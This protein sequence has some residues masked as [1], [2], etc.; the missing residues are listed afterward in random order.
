MYISKI[1]LRDDIE[2][3]ESFWQILQDGYQIH[4][5]LWTLFT[6][7][8]ERRRDFLYRQEQRHG[9]PIF[10]TVSERQ[11]KAGDD[12]WYVES[13]PYTP[14]MKAGQRLGFVLCANPIRSKRD[15]D[16]KQHR[17]DVVMEAK[18]KLKNEGKWQSR[19]PSE[20]ELIQ[21]AGFAWLAFRAE[22]HGFAVTDGEVRC[23]GYRQHLWYKPKGQHQVRLS[24]VDFNGLLTVFDPERF[25]EALYHGIGPA[26]GFGCGL[27][28]VRPV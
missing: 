27:M 23:D 10:F 16:Q 9:T 3:T 20:A 25:K 8:P 2:K 15:A 19:R 17:H 12:L 28:L 6:D 1:Q 13:K 11:P 18:T 7:S 21:E 22:Q 26:K 5:Q 14:Q 24:T 4:R